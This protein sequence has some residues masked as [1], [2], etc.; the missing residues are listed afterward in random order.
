[1]SCCYKVCLL[2]LFFDPFPFQQGG[3]IVYGRGLII[4]FPTSHWVQSLRFLK[5]RIALALWTYCCSVRFSFPPPLALSCPNNF[6]VDSVKFE[7]FH[8]AVSFK[9]QHFTLPVIDSPSNLSLLSINFLLTSAVNSGQL[10]TEYF[11][12]SKFKKSTL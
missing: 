4:L 8:C 10:L 5:T 6:P 3:I 2:H 11:Q 7:R 9:E 1:M 12:S